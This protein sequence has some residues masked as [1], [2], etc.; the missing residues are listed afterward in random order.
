MA[1]A[2]GVIGLTMESAGIF[3]DTKVL[4]SNRVMISSRGRCLFS[5]NIS[6]NRRGLS[7]QCASKIAFSL[8]IWRS[9][10]LFFTARGFFSK[11]FR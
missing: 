5:M 10:A 2:T 1:A 9:A 3:L 7:A 11:V 4:P 8:G 6:T